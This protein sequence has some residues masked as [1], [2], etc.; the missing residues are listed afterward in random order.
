MDD[1][2]KQF[3]LK[4]NKE[5]N[6]LTVPGDINFA[7]GDKF[8]LTGIKMPQ[9]YIDNASSQLAEEAQTWLDEHCEKRIQ[10]RGKCDEVLFR[11]MNLFIACG[12]MVGVYSDQLKIDRE[13]R[14]TKVKRYIEN[15]DKP[16]YRYELTLSDFLQGNGFKDLVNDVDKFPDEIEDKEIGRASCRERVSA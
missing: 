14:V 13:I 1:K 11:Q 16:A 15:D 8:I 10:L 12:Q 5:E 7:V 6:A 2:I 3:K 4:E 9:V